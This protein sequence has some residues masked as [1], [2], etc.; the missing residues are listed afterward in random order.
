[1][2]FT[3]IDF[4]TANE[5][6]HPCALGLAVVENGQIVR[7]ES[8]LIRPYELNIPK[9]Y[10]DIH[11]I[12]EDMVADMPEF[13]E[14]WDAIRVFIEGQNIIAHNAPFDIG[15]LKSA[16]D[17]YE[18]PYPAFNYACTVDISR[19]TWAKPRIVPNH[20]LNTMAAHLGVEFRHHDASDD[21]YAAAVIALEAAKKAKAK[22]FEELLTRLGTRL[23]VFGEVGSK[24]RRGEFAASPG[25][26]APRNDRTT[27]PGSLKYVNGKFVRTKPKAPRL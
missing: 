9:F 13:N 10:S 2:N 25:E 18:I 17:L 26:Q 5:K 16:L 22:T 7:R 14:R 8:W 15:V 6:G 23:C 21:A 11:G 3:A 27:R 4:E 1:M 24:A 20:K 19:K 12:T